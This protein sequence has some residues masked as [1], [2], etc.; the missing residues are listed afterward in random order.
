MR[1]SE[2]NN[3]LYTGILLKSPKYTENYNKN[4]LS[5]MPVL[6]VQ[7][8]KSIVA[9]VHLW[10]TDHFDCIIRPY[11]FALYQMLWLIAL[12]MGDAGQLYNE[13]VIYHY[14][15]KYELSKG[16]LDVKCRVD[17]ELLRSILAK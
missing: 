1:N 17:S 9:T 12:S 8:N 7:G 16:E 3:Q 4:N 13:T 15:Y 6:M 11:E 14:L 2:T 10:L 5:D